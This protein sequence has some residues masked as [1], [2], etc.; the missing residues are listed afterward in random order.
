MVY[1][2]SNGTNIKIGYTSQAVEKRLNQ[3]NSGSDAN[4]FICGFMQG[5]MSKEKELHKQFGH[6]RLRHNAEWFQPTQELL[7][8][9]NEHSEMQNTYVDTLGVKV[10]VYKT[11]SLK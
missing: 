3:L 4:L 6:V 11:M 9:I 7:D 10:M 2:I 1:F 5:D 8:Y